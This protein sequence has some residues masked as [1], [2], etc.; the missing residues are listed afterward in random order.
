ME[1]ASELNQLNHEPVFIVSWTGAEPG[2][3]GSCT[4]TN[5]VYAVDVPVVV[6]YKDGTP[7]SYIDVK[8]S[9]SQSGRVRTDVHGRAQLPT[10]LGTTL[11]V[12]ATSRLYKRYVYE[13]FTETTERVEQDTV[14]RLVLDARPPEQW[15]REEA[16]V[17]YEEAVNEGQLEDRPNKLEY[18]INVFMSDIAREVSERNRAIEWCTHLQRLQRGAES[19]DSSREAF[20]TALEDDALSE[21]ARARL[22]EWQT[23]M[24]DVH[25]F[26][27]K[28][29]EFLLDVV[30]STAEAA[31]G[32]DFDRPDC[33]EVWAE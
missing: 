6:T 1:D 24:E 26:L 16:L 13:Y 30:S 23:R 5:E 20:A 14:F 18:H 10:F 7:A 12:T 15:A 17:R 19:R 27:P 11:K 33:D 25:R 29:N 28:R 32:K 9:D 21:A 3:Q 2:V 8:G 4:V 31:S 22:E